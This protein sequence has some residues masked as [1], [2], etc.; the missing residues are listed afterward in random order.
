MEERRHVNYLQRTV[1]FEKKKRAW[2]Q[3]TYEYKGW[4]ESIG[5]PAS[6]RAGAAYCVSDVACSLRDRPSRCVALR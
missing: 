1:K 3:E 5:P 2:V 6:Q 4:A